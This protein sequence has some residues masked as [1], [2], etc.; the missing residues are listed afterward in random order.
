MWKTA[1]VNANAGVANQV[2]VKLEA[3]WE[4]SVL[5]LDGSN[6]AGYIPIPDSH[7]VILDLN[8][9]II[10]R[11]LCNEEGSYQ[12]NG[13]VIH[14]GKYASLTIED[15]NANTTHTGRY[16][17]G[18]WYLGPHYGQLEAGDLRGGIIAGGSNSENGGAIVVEKYAD[19]V[20]HAGTI[21]GNQ[22]KSNGGAL[23]VSASGAHAVINGGHILYNRSAEHGGGV[24]VND[25]GFLA[26]LSGDISYNTVT[27]NYYGGGVY[28]D[29]G[30]SVSGYLDGK[31]AAV[32]MTGGSI[33]NNTAQYGGGL[34]QESGNVILTGGT[35]AN[36]LAKK[37]GG[38]VY[39]NGHNGTT[40]GVHLDGITI[41][42]N[43]AKQDGGGF[44]TNTKYSEIHTA[45]ITYNT[46][47]SGKGSGV[48]IGKFDYLYL[49]GGQI[50]IQQNSKSNLYQQTSSDLVKP[51]LGENSSVYISTAGFSTSTYS[52]NHDITNSLSNSTV[53]INYLHSDYNGYIIT[54]DDGKVIYYPGFPAKNPGTDSAPTSTTV[55]GT[56]YSVSKGTFQYTSVLDTTDLSSVYYYSDGYF[57]SDTSEYLDHLST[58][59]LNFAMSAFQRP[60]ANTSDTYSDTY[61]SQ[62]V[63]DFLSSTGFSNYQ[64]NYPE[65][66]ETEEGY[67]IGSAI[68]S[69]QLAN[70]GK[71][72]IAVAVRGANYTSEWASNVT[73]SDTN[74]Q[75]ANAEAVGFSNAADQ[76]TQRV[77]D[78]ISKY[79]TGDDY[80]IWI[81]GY[82]RGGATANLTAQRLSDKYGSEHV[83]GYTFEAPQGGTKYQGTHLKAYNKYT[84]IH[85]IV[86]KADIVPMVA[87]SIMGYVR[88]GVDH[89][90]P[91]SNSSSDNSK[92]YY[93]VDSSKYNQLK[94]SALMQL[95]AI[96]PR[97]AFD[98]DFYQAQMK[99]ILGATGLF[100]MV[101]T[102][103]VQGKEAENWYDDFIEFFLKNSLDPSLLCIRNLGSYSAKDY[104]YLYS[105]KTWGVSSASS[106]SR[107]LG[108]LDSSSTTKITFQQA[109]QDF[110]GIYFGM[111][112]EKKTQFTNA[113]TNSLSDKIGVVKEL[114]A[115]VYVLRYWNASPQLIKNLHLKS[116][117]SIVLNS[118]TSS[119]LTDEEWNKLKY[120]LPV[121]LD[122]MLSFVCS[123]YQYTFAVPEYLG[124][125]L[126]NTESIAQGHYPENN[127]AWL[128][129]LDSN[130]K[131][132]Y[133]VLPTTTLFGT[134]EAPTSDLAETMYTS[135]QTLHL[136]SET[137]G[138]TIY[139]TFDGS[140]PSITNQQAK[141]YGTSLK[142]DGEDQV[143]Q[144]ITIKAI[145]YKDGVYSEVSTFHYCIFKNA[146]KHKVYVDNNY[147][148]S[149]YP[150]ETVTIQTTNTAAHTVFDKWTADDS[151]ISFDNAESLSAAFRMGSKD[152]HITSVKQ[153]KIHTVNL[154]LDTDLTSIEQATL[155]P[156]EMD[157]GTTHYHSAGY[158]PQDATEYASADEKD[159]A[160]SWTVSGNTASLSVTIPDNPDIGRV[161]D[162]NSAYKLDRNLKVTVNG[163]E[164]TGA[165]I[166]NNS[167]GSLTYTASFTVKSTVKSLSPQTI[168]FAH[169]DTN[170][171][172]TWTPGT[173]K[174]NILT[175]AG[176]IITDVPLTF[177]ADNL[178]NVTEHY[179]KDTLTVQ[180]FT[181][182]G[183][184]SSQYLSDN[185]SILTDTV[186]ASS[187]EVTVIFNAK[188]IPVVKAPTA[189]PVS[190]TALHP[191][192]TVALS[193]ETGTDIYYTTD[194]S[195]P[196]KTS[197]KYTDPIQV[198]SNGTELNIKAIA[199]SGNTASIVSSFTYPIEIQ[200]KLTVK[201]Y[202]TA[203]KQTDPLQDDLIYTYTK[204]SSISLT[205]PAIDDEQFSHWENS[206][207]SLFS[208]D[209]TISLTMSEDSTLRAIYIPA[210]SKLNIAVG[211]LVPGGKLASLIQS[212]DVTITKTYYA[213]PANFNISWDPSS[214]TVQYG[215]TYSLRIQLEADENGQIGLKK[216]DT[217]DSDYTK[218]AIQYG[219]NRNAVITVNGQPA[220]LQKDDSGEYI[221]M[222][223]TT[224]SLVYQSTA[225]ETEATVE[226][227]TSLA[228]MPLPQ[229]AVI[230]AKAASEKTPEEVTVNTQNWV[231]TNPSSYDSSSLSANTL[232]FEGEV[233]V[234]NSITGTVPKVTFTVHVK[235]A[236]DMDPVIADPETGST[237]TEQKT[238]TL[239]C[240]TEDADIYYMIYKDG[241]TK[242]TEYTLGDTAVLTGIA[243]SDVTYHIAAHAMHA[244]RKQIADTVFTY[245][246]SLP[247]GYP[248]LK[249]PPLSDGTVGD[250]YSE[251]L[252]DSNNPDDTVYTLAYDF[253][254][255]GLKLDQ[256][257]GVIS[258][259]PQMEGTYYFSI[260][261][262]NSAGT[263]HVEYSIN[264]TDEGGTFDPYK[265]TKGMNGEWEE[266]SNS[267]L[268]FETDGAY[269]I[270]KN[271]YIDGVKVDE[272][273]YTAKIGSTKLTLSPELLKTL[274][275]G[276]HTI[277]ADYQNG[278]EP[279]TVFNVTEASKEPKPSKCLGD[280]YWDEKTQACVVYDPSEIPDTSVK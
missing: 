91:G 122:A 163:N 176:N 107:S 143:K 187:A 64:I 178:K 206:D 173:V 259:T 257:T 232:T 118:S 62:N 210:I 25:G 52:T 66:S 85:N 220:S 137:D 205:A 170:L 144:T 70:T 13:E 276:Q 93:K 148:G 119:L 268:Y 116:Y 80:A 28:T 203:V 233:N 214:S 109:L 105:T 184:I 18:I 42:Y 252:A 51:S 230:T 267:I 40:T 266:E 15:S 194:G 78:Y 48:Y 11:H 117:E 156:W 54:K 151:T 249:Q 81:V 169:S 224:E 77:N 212:A 188:D 79:G 94:K 239:S 185:S 96:D 68:A 182:T 72:L 263:S 238:V 3:D 26:L 60:K 243:G 154:V 217:E 175:T 221:Q 89:Y 172:D 86:N 264:I 223:F 204:D 98:D 71:K 69:K 43:T 195:E 61:A 134:P 30:A 139:Y 218:Y 36:N 241:D 127:L 180:T 44:Y 73:I 255:A 45:T 37:D 192:D 207:G 31:S 110:I 33:C 197:A 84:N 82:S 125:L 200:K 47:N 34:Y 120:D 270:F 159:A 278:Q 261:A 142:I 46:A 113:V 215:Q 167:D 227:G 23:D 222:T 90:I 226:N 132:D 24:Y 179:S 67:T 74:P 123:D 97:I 133:A 274:S 4:N 135:G 10:N 147:I 177:N 53:N 114:E 129:S 231:L 236:E 20:M 140:T 183:T 265:F 160:A 99:Y 22:S 174:T 253:L 101:N 245:K 277:M 6:V 161:Y 216:K 112:A 280:A 272:D 29:S 279:A 5:Y 141:A 12:K 242:P 121:I 17:N 128:R 246:V 251:K 150:E 59:S 237:L 103:L 149:Y 190:Q 269:S 271:L 199:Y 186:P 166:M 153:D 126:N 273:L 247:E 145:A 258:G 256:N 209:R 76:V 131:N 55:N 229:T 198:P 202:D 100:D 49:T 35:I 138:A 162:V 196:S 111:S 254:P 152:V 9:H 92:D 88:Y 275:L 262:S 7:Y 106:S 115:W 191:G 181:M 234:P 16:E 250:A 104:R 124:T 14:V 21:A 211:A 208:E 244:N 130:Y 171:D 136:S 225:I 63:A 57:V 155:L 83:Y 189:S 27:G 2:T 39:A 219:W 58:L 50:V 8:G 146:A 65:P 260:E 228:S 248:V 102:T 213:D 240:D 193:A 168:V 38:G 108:V 235:E 19:F 158:T 87:P 75:N 157:N 201:A 164:L 1:V 32:I 95:A 41:S 165:A 56:E